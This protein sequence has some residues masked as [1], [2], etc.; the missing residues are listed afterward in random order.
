M[1]ARIFGAGIAA[2]LLSAVVLTLVQQWQVVPLILKAE[3]YEQ[4]E[5]GGFIHANFQL[6]LA[7]DTGAPHVHEDHL[8]DYGHGQADGHHHDEDAWAPEDGLERSFFTFAANVVAGVGFGLLLAGAMALSGR[9]IQWREGLIW[10]LAGF[11]VFSL[12]P[13]LG[14]APEVPGSAAAALS[15]RQIWWMGCVVASA[16]GLALT[17]FGKNNLVRTAGV[18][19]LAIPHVIG[20]PHPSALEPGGVPPELAAQYVVASLFA[21]LIFWLALGASLGRLFQAKPLT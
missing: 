16:V 5:S 12:A 20:A 1:I 9:V 19:T 6:Q 7:H 2:G 17:A 3:T 14:L 21:T 10:G 15:D 4:A 8:H 13:T 18:L 11:S